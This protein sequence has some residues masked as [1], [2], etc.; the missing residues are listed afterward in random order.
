[1]H[2]FSVCFVDKRRTL[3]VLLKVRRSYN[4]DTILM[5]FTWNIY[6]LVFVKPNLVDFSAELFSSG[7]LSLSVPL[8]CS[9]WAKPIF[10]LW[11]FV[12]SSVCA[13]CMLS[14]LVNNILFPI[15]GAFWSHGWFIFLILPWFPKCN[16]YHGNRLDG[17]PCRLSAVNLLT[18]APAKRGATQLH[19]YTHIHIINR[20]QRVNSAAS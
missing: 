14:N 6:T 19:S 18:P 13:T 16:G 15:L 7:S 4:S 1:M 11:W 20:T 9:V 10:R 12:L 17:Q 3:L 8:C 5:Q 2:Q